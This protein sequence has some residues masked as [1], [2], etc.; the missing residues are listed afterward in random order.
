MGFIRKLPHTLIESF[1]STL[2]EVRQSDV[3]LHVVGLEHARFE[4]HMQVVQQTLLEIG[5][6]GLPTI[7]VFN[8]IDACEASEKNLPALQREYPDAVFISA[9]WGIGL[10]T[11]RQQLADLV[12][13]DHIETVACIPV[14]DGKTLSSIRHLAN[15]I[16]EKLVQ[17]QQA[18][19]TPLDALRVRF[20]AGPAQQSDLQT[21]LAPYT[22]LYPIPQN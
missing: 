13:R 1:K 18:G 3:L 14:T 21:A 6:L 10:D 20:R 5:A 7:L 16:E 19:S 4:H 17:V 11:L 9:L 8:K 2:D 22:K 12:R 15:V